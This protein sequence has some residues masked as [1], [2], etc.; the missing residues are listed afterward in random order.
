VTHRSHLT[1]T[2]SPGIK[3]ASLNAFATIDAGVL[4]SHCD[5][6]RTDYEIPAVVYL[7]EQEIMATAGTT[8]TE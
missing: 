4:V 7:H 5:I 3:N 2:K 8:V 6:F 1:I